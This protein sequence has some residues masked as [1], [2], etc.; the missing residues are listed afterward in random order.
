[1]T[2]LLARGLVPI[3]TASGIPMTTTMATEMP[4]TISVSSESCQKPRRPK[5]RKERQTSTAMR[6]LAIARPMYVAIATTPSQPISGTGRGGLGTTIIRCTHSKALRSRSAMA[7]VN[8]MTGLVSRPAS[9]AL[10]ISVSSSC[11]SVRATPGR[12]SVSVPWVKYQTTIHTAT[13]PAAGIQRLT[14]VRSGGGGSAPGSTG[15]GAAGAGAVVVTPPP[16]PRRPA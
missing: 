10:L 4:V 16:R 8:C 1:M 6:Q 9:S 14:R 12:A 7:L 15:F 2:T 11:R 5:E 13:T 3:R